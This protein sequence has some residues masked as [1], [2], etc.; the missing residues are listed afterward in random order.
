MPRT[1]QEILNHGED[2]ARRFEEFDPDDL[3]DAAPLR[4]L[5]D[6]VISRSEAEKSVADAVQAARSEDV[7]WAA[8]GMILGTSGEAARQRYGR[9]T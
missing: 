6:A 8:I 7:P 4:T 5:R 2:L 1:T 9:S 3:R